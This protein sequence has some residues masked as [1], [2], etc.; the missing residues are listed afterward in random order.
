M[1]IASIPAMILISIV[2]MVFGMIFMATFSPR[3]TPG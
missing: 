1:A 2:Y 3:V